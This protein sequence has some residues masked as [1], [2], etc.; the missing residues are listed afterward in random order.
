MSGKPY[1]ISHLQ[2]K[3]QVLSAA[4]QAL[5]SKSLRPPIN[6]EMD[7]DPVLGTLLLLLGAQISYVLDEIF[8]VTPRISSWLERLLG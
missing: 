5:S 8:V 3:K 4:L 2:H 1:S 6:Q 7:L